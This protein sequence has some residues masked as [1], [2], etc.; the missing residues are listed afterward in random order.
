MFSKVLCSQCI[1]FSL[2]DLLP[3]EEDGEIRGETPKL[4]D[5]VKYISEEHKLYADVSVANDFISC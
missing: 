3:I 5:A 2:Q 4:T 1:V